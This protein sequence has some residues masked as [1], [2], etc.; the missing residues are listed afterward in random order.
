MAF[1]QHMPIMVNL[2]PYLSVVDYINLKRAV[3]RLPSA[4]IS[5]ADLLFRRLVSRLGTFTQLDP[6][7][8]AE[9]IRLLCE[10]DD[11]YISGGFLVAL[12]RGDPFDFSVQD[13]DFF[14]TEASYQS[15]EKLKTL[16][17]TNPWS[18]SDEP[19]EEY[20]HVMPFSSVFNILNSQ[21]QF[22]AHTSK[23][24]VQQSIGTFDLPLCRNYFSFKTGLRIF[25]L[26]D[27]T[28]QRTTVETSQ[29]LSRIFGLQHRTHLIRIYEKN[30]G[31][32]EKYRQRGFDVRVNVA[33]PEVLDSLLPPKGG[34]PTYH[35]TYQLMGMHAPVSCALGRVCRCKTER[36][37]KECYR[38]HHRC[39]C[40]SHILFNEQA[41][42]R[43]AKWRHALM[44]KEHIEFWSN[45]AK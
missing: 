3:V 28:T 42:E 18:L 16:P 20:A 34:T 39:K 30:R 14:V 45:N 33:T 40:K 7:V 17:I 32:I 38:V 35:V 25:K 1:W 11:F 2:V 6:S 22:I 23:K 5:P 19:D 24:D 44:I 41:T 12:L 27:L 29:L 37:N 10:R 9:L 21:I 43:Y 15:S 4:I 36:Y 13:L 26:E 31:R 8:I